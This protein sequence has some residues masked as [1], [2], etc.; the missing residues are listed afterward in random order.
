MS[1]EIKSAEELRAMDLDVLESYRDQLT[2]SRSEIED[3]EFVRAAQDV[4]SAIKYRNAET[5]LRSAAIQTVAA[6]GFDPI[7]RSAEPVASEPVDVYDTVEYRTA[8]KDAF[9]NG[10]QMPVEYRDAD[11]VTATSD[12][13][14]VI[15]TVTVNQIIAK[16][17]SE[18]MI[19]P[20]VR[21]SA[22]PAGIAYP[23]STFVATASWVNEGAGSYTQKATTSSITFAYNKLRC[24]ISRTME[25]KTM[26]L[27]AFESW[28]VEQVSKAMLV[29]IE[30]AIV[31]G[32]GSGQPSGIL[33]ETPASGQ[34]LE[35]ASATPL[36]YATLCAAEA[37]LPVAYE[38]GAKW[39]MSK[40]TFMSFVGM[41]DDNGQ[42]IARI[43]HGIDG[44]PERFLLGREVIVNPY[45]ASF[46]AAPSADTVFAFLFKPEDYLLNTVYN[47]G[48]QTRQ[49]WDTED[50]ETKAVMSV[51][52][53]VLDKNSLVTLTQKKA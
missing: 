32:T 20:L 13:T 34:A 7:E 43:D 35:Y 10:T 5:E 33:A 1:F 23:T 8:F 45:V 50:W 15:P 44:R 18:G 17:T 46:V 16:L 25:V 24:E 31:N 48:I 42:P 30:T 49:N 12:V 26:S 40:A 6:G 11:A 19:F 14:T 53:K 37:A 51:D 3:A 38:D 4:V 52:G 9:A 27:S 47:M 22:V 36:S 29:A 39:F 41:V 21:K 28:F 2:E